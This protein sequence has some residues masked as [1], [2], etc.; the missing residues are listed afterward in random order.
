MGT[1]YGHTLK[2]C[3]DTGGDLQEVISSAMNTL[4]PGGS[5]NGGQGIQLAYKVA[6]DNY[7]PGGTNRVILCSDGDFNVGTTS[8]AELI[9][10][11]EK[12]A[13]QKDP[14]KVARFIRMAR[15]ALK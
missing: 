4:R 5:T 13:G 8:T 12:N 11:V 3:T 1:W 15:E 2:V 7:I 6:L 9:R 14:E 10:M